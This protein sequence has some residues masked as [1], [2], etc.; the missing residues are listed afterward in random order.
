MGEKS[1]DGG[2]KTHKKRFRCFSAK[3]MD[4]RRS[5]LSRTASPAVVSVASLISRLPTKLDAFQFRGGGKKKQK[6]TGSP[7]AKR[8]GTDFGWRSRI[9]FWQER[10]PVKCVSCKPVIRPEMGT[11][12]QTLCVANGKR[13]QVDFGTEESFIG[14]LFHFRTLL[15][16]CGLFQGTSLA[17][18]QSDVTKS[19]LPT[20]I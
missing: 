3:K 11:H 4:R 8:N 14:S 2:R 5:G 16:I 17:T 7:R 19:L 1:G 6:K 15:Q 13:K 9:A 12:R 20:F 18:E 10:T